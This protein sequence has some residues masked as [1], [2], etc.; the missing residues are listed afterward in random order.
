MIPSDIFHVN[1]KNVARQILHQVGKFQKCEIF[2]FR[3]TRFD[4]QK[5]MTQIFPSIHEN[6]KINLSIVSNELFSIQVVKLGI[7]KQ[8][9]RF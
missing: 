1:T 4:C 5:I 7:F 8:F 2:V 3:Q 9:T 6:G